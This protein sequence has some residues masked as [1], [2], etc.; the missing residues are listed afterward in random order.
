VPT[1]TGQTG[2]FLQT[3]GTA[4][5]WQNPAGDIESITATSPL[6]GGGTSGAIT[7]GIQAGTTTQ[8]GAVQ[9]TDSISSTS[10]TTA[11]TPNSV[12][13]TYD[14]ANAA[15]PKSLVDA[16]GDIVTAT[17]DNTP[18]RVAVGTNEHRL[19]AASGETTGLKYVADTTNYAVGAKGDLLAGTAAD[20]VA[21]LAVGN[22]GET[23]VADSSAT[24]GL[25]YQSAYNGNGVINGGMD[26]WQR[27][28]SFALLSPQTAYTADRWL[29]RHLGTN[30]T[31]TQQTSGLTG[32]QYSLRIQRPNGTSGT[33][34]QQI[35]YNFET[36]DSYRFAGQTIT[37]S[38]WAKA[39][40]N[41]SSTSS[42]LASEAY[43][44]TGVNQNITQGA[45][46][47]Q[48]N[49]ASKNNTLTTSWQRFSVTGTV[50]ST[51]TQIALIFSA[52]PT[53]TA[54]TNDWYEITGVQVELGSVATSFK[55][56]GSGGG[57]IQGELAAC[58]RYYQAFPS[59]TQDGYALFGSGYAASTTKGYFCL[60]LNTPMR[61]YPTMA[62]SAGNTFAVHTG[63]STVVAG[64]A[65]ATDRTT[66][67][68]VW[69]NITVA[70]GLTA[71]NGVLGIGNNTTSA[72]ME[73]SS[74]L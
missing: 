51:A 50:G 15:I 17:A 31:Y 29:A 67:E 66:A 19:V 74:E 59:A 12:K 24:T 21:A 39:G 60:K 65:I 7:V 41:F 5:S 73:A 4:V 6:T 22:N 46:T 48:V 44:G 49:F 30:V 18:A 43:S 3:D 71:G 64:T 68:T 53:G 1:Q 70:S 57:T 8:A 47:G 10:T 16:K 55:R 38:F 35:Y 27:G 32:F 37:V 63:V 9:L 28:T 26:I 33:D 40:A 54:S 13:T 36:V 2:K 62:Y 25:R 52:T 20:T 58:Q 61:T 34:P 69:F 11:V 23:L 45:L 14:L 42:I 72:K 56:S